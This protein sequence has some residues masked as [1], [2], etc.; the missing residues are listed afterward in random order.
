MDTE[1]LYQDT[2]GLLSLIKNDENR[3]LEVLN[4]LE[5]LQLNKYHTG[6]PLEVPDEYKNSIMQIGEALENHFICFLNPETFE[7]EQV[8]CSA[9][10]QS[11]DFEE[12]NDDRLGE[13]DLNYME[14]NDYI[15]FEPL[16]FN[17]TYLVMEK[18]VAQ[19]RDEELTRSLEDSL[20]DEKPVTGFLRIIEENNQMENWLAYKKQAIVEYV[21]TRLLNEL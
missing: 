11:E 20:S 15:R 21:T 18:Y 19:R 8:D 12:Q 6:S 3:L 1:K 17:E 10:F 14:W 2:L 4:L 9:Y 16:N 7:I 5:N 13:F